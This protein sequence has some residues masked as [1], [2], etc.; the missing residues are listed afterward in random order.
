MKR[1]LTFS[2][3][4]AA[5]L[6]TPLCWAQTN[7][8]ASDWKPADT[9]QQGNHVP[10]LFN[11]QEAKEQSDEPK[12]DAERPGRGGPIELGPDDKQV[13]PDPPEGIIAKRDGIAHGK[14][15]M[16]DYDSKTVGT[17]RNMN[18]YTP[19]GYTNEKK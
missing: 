18:V 17:T 12:P 11:P 8:P 2:T 15:E 5:L 7:E 9:N 1:H 14:L 10:I 3:L 16:I 13:Y 19:P 6:A 4:V